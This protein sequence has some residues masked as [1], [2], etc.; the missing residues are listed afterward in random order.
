MVSEE[1]WDEVTEDVIG[2]YFPKHEYYTAFKKM[3]E[4]LENEL[5]EATRQK[6]KR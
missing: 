3:L 5:E 1:R 6:V 4:A 2:E